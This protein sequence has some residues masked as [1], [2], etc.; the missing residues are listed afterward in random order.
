[1][2]ITTLRSLENTPF[3]NYT[4]E[5]WCLYYCA[6]Y[7]GIDGSHHKDWLID[8][9]VRILNDTEVIVEKYEYEDGEFEYVVNLEDAS[10][11]Y[12]GWVKKYEQYDEETDETLYDWD[13]GIAP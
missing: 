2:T 1:M 3:E 8:Q 10:S 13:E 12:W 5:D 9:I 4:K 6:E 11:E 7:G